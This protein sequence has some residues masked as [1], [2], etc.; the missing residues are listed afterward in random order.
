MI[1]APVETLEHLALNA[2]PRRQQFR[3]VF[4]GIRSGVLQPA[5]QKLDGAD[6]E[7]GL[8]LRPSCGPSWRRTTTPSW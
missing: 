2:D 1:I 6:S 3:I 5:G 4:F 7:E 8:H